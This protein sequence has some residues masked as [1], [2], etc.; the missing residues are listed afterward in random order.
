MTESP[1]GTR[2]GARI[3]TGAWPGA[4]VRALFAASPRI[5][6]GARATW[7]VRALDYV[8]CRPHWRA[9]GDP[10]PGDLAGADVLVVVKYTDPALIR[11]ARADGI[12]VVW[13]MTDLYAK[14]REPAAF[15]DW[16]AAQD[17]DRIVAMLLRAVP[18]DLVIATNEVMRRDFEAAGQRAATV[19]IHFWPGMRMKPAVSEGPLAAVYDGDPDYLDAGFHAIFRAAARRAGIAE[20]KTSFNNQV[21]E[22]A[23]LALS[24]RPDDPYRWLHMRW[25][26]PLKTVNALAAGVPAVTLP[27]VGTLEM[28]AHPGVFCFW[29]ESS[30]ANA[31][32]ACRSPALRREVLARAPAFRESH[33]VEAACRAWERVFAGLLGGSSRH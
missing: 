10:S 16:V 21:G 26:P 17:L 12:P 14:I 25:K 29:D 9:V 20:L 27:E 28:G 22:I 5:L 4:E 18:S 33:G 1:A 23:D 2:A 13:D 15:P 30:L 3:E 31:L 8:A 11:A 7:H 6:E 32:L 24:Y 19:P